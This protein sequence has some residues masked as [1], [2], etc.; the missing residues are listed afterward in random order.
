MII[1]VDLDGVV[2]AFEPEIRRDVTT[3]RPFD[4]EELQPARTWDMDKAYD[5][6]E[7]VMDKIF[8][9]SVLDRSLFH[10]GNAIEGAAVAINSLSRRH[11]VRFVTEPGF[12]DDPVV[13]ATA[14]GQKASWLA[15]HGLGNYPLICVNGSKQDYPADVIVDDNPNTTGWCQVGALNIAFNQPWNSLIKYEDFAVALG[16]VRADGWQDV[17]DAI[18]RHE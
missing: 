14:I 8:R 17:L 6:S 18:A 15:A 3:Y 11:T 9:D 12:Q 2:Y 10:R 16:L 5:V 13:R 1:N 4:G 7:G